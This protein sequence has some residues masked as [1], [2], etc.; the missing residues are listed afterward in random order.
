MARGERRSFELDVFGYLGVGAGLLLVVFGYRLFA[1]ASGTDAGTTSG[2]AIVNVLAETG[3]V[4]TRPEMMVMGLGVLI[5]LRRIVFRAQA[6]DKKVY[7][8][9]GR[10][11]EPRREIG[12]SEVRVFGL[13]HLHQEWP[14][15]VFRSGLVESDNPADYL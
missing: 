12:S 3:M 13:S 6:Q 1:Q 4:G 10:T 14:W 5:V 8:K 7:V 15:I 2:M 11:Y 9:N